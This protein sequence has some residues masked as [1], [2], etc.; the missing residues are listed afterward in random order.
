MQIVV[1]IFITVII[2]FTKTATQESVI[3][4]NKRQQFNKTFFISK[5]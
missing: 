5:R 1:I 2:A 4:S 3:I